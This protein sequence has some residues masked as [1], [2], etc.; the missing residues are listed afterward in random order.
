MP[1]SIFNSV[2]SECTPNLCDSGS[3]VSYTGIS[4]CQEYCRRLEDDVRYPDSIPPKLS[5][6]DLSSKAAGKD[7]SSSDYDREV[8]VI[9]SNTSEF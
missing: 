4:Q 9:Y 8:R 6:S 7:A 5:V 3:L 1:Y 2:K